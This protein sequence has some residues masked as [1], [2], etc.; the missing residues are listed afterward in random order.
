MQ[1]TPHDMAQPHR[2]RITILKVTEF[3][4]G[5]CT[6]RNLLEW[7]AV[8]IGVLFLKGCIADQYLIPSHSMEPTLEGGNFF[9]GDRVLVNKCIF[10]I[11]IPFTTI[12][13]WTWSHPQRWDIVVFSPPHEHST[14]MPVI[15]RVV[16]LPGET[17]RIR[18][19]K[20]EINGN[21]VTLP[22]SM[23][24]DLYYFNDDDIL[25]ESLNH[26]DPRV[27]EILTDARKKYPLK[28]GCRD[29]TEYTQIPSGCYFL[30][31]DNSINSIDSRMYG[32]VPEHRIIG[33]AVAIFWPLSRRRDLTGFTQ[34]WWGKVVITLPIT[35]L[36][37]LISIILLKYLFYKNP[38]HPKTPVQ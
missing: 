13:L 27:R 19:G 24:A 33:K 31:G 2:K 15:K 29:E 21:P 11:R 4:I 16:G 32:W 30:L 5:P 6:R 8:I 1:T 17:V 20:L 3:L 37:G 12:R 10:G 36:L 26:P 18:K 14:V 22:S 7:L 9:T 28:Y 34:T 23:P 25:Y 38:K 35:L